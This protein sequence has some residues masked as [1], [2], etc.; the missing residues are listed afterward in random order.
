MNFKTEDFNVYMLYNNDV[1]RIFNESKYKCR[2]HF[3]ADDNKT[4]LLCNAGT[5]RFV[6]NYNRSIK[7]KTKVKKN[8]KTLLHL[9]DLQPQFDNNEIHQQYLAWRLE[10]DNTNCND[11]ESED[12]N[13]LN[14]IEKDNN[15]DKMSTGNDNKVVV[16]SNR[17]WENNDVKSPVEH[18]KTNKDDWANDNDNIKYE[19]NIKE[20][21]NKKENKI[22]NKNKD[23]NSRN[24][25]KKEKIKD[26]IITEDW[27]TNNK[28]EENMDI[29]I[30][31]K[32][33]DDFEN[34]YIFQSKLLDIRNECLKHGFIMGYSLVKISDF[35]K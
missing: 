18:F 27:E 30:D 35:S 32:I 8:K 23:E 28:N 21:E 20:K 1:I 34:S 11:I 2:V 12:D 24:K 26:K 17:G 3:Y 7:L 9:D 5:G 15:Q 13:K 31:K 16:K 10:I 25:I 4:S 33:N 6:N 29:T 14:E 22:K 19:F